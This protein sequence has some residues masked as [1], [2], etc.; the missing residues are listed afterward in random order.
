MW[1]VDGVLLLLAYGDL[2]SKV[3]PSSEELFKK[4]AFLSS[5]PWYWKVIILLAANILLMGKGT[6]TALRK[7]EDQ[8]DVYALQLK[9]IE[10]S[11]PRIVLRQPGAISVSN[12]AFLS[13]SVILFTAPIVRVRF[14]NDPLHPCPNAIAKDIVAKVQFFKANSLMFEMDGRWA[15]S[16]QASL[17]DFRQS[18]N[19]LLKMEFAIGGEHDLDIALR[20]PASGVCFAWNNDNYN[21]PNMLKPEH[22]MDGDLFRVVVRLRGSW[23]EESFVFEFKNSSGSL[24]VL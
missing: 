21:Y 12:T 17:R 9:Q 14:M 10:E 5:L 22:R 1:S 23:V 3:V 18:R 20:D 11:K 15:D 24:E 8:R 2:A 13:N 16:D 19:D 4:L 7:R 6:L